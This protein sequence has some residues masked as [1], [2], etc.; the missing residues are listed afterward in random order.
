MTS[1]CSLIM[2]GATIA[3]L[4]RSVWWDNRQRRG[5]VPGLEPSSPKTKP[6][7][8]GS[9]CGGSAQRRAVLVPRPA[10]LRLLGGLIEVDLHFYVFDPRERDFVRFAA[11]VG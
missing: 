7:R 3:F 1:M 4:H 2:T 9:G 8:P 5:T 10:R 11:S 6:P